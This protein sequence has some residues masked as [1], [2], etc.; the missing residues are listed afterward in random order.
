MYE[1]YKDRV[2][3]LV[4]YIREAH[5]IDGHLPMEFGMIEDPITTVERLKV[6]KQCVT[7]LKLVMPAIV[8][9]MDDAVSMAYHG[10]PERLYL[11]GKDGKV[12]YAGGPGPFQFEPN[13]L[14]K[15][16][17]V[18]IGKAATTPGKTGAPA[19]KKGG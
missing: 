5:P 12:A 4:V 18:V 9:K 2:E 15:A 8:D 6:A 17:R 10:W 7:G 14:E 11:I 3:F 1:K 16:I 13:E 19:G